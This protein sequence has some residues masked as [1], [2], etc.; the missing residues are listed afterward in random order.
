[1]IL[2]FVS[3]GKKIKN[4]DLA[5]VFKFNSKVCAVTVFKHMTN[6]GNFI[7]AISILYTGKLNAVKK[8]NYDKHDI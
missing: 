6:S 2:F 8:L 3:I 7:F 5:E 1:M 4:T